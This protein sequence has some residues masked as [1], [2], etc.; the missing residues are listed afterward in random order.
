MISLTSSVADLSGE[1]QRAWAVELLPRSIRPEAARHLASSEME[2][3]ARETKD[4]F[5]Q[6]IL[7]GIYFS[8]LSDP[9]T[10]AFRPEYLREML[11]AKAVSLIS[12]LRRA[13]T[14][15]KES[16]IDGYFYLILVL[17]CLHPV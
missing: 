12:K 10:S 2:R 14:A 7:E 13:I 8:A 15:F 4:P 1:S 3:P 16:A 17:G 6:K 5:A 11:A 9:G